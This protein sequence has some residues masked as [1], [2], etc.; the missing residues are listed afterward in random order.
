MLD[1]GFWTGRR[2]LLTGHTGFKGAWLWLMLRRLGARPYGLALEPATK[3][4][5]FNEAGLASDP[6]SCVG[7]I[8][9]PRTVQDA[10]DR[11]G[12]D[13]IIHMAA[14]ALV[15]PSYEN[16]IETYQTNVMGTVNLLEAVRRNHGVRAV[17][18]VTSDKCYRNR[19]WAWAYRE[20]EP[21]GGHDPYSS[22][23]ACAEIVAESWRASFFGN[24]KAGIATARAGNVIGGGDWSPDRLVVD[25]AKAFLD[26]R[27]VELRRPAS[28]RPWQHVLEPLTGYLTLAKALI[29]TPDAAQAWNF[30][31]Y[32]TDA[33]RVD[34]LVA[35]FAT[36]WGDG[37]RWSASAVAVHH[38]AGS[39][40]IDASKAR[41]RLGWK[42]KLDVRQAASWTADWYRRWASGEAAASLCTEQ[43]ETYFSR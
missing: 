21:L 12:P 24:G 13:I 34:A 43:I 42:P 7:D 27:P 35:H 15:Y 29:E 16:P 2:V 17:V 10:I 37:A 25:C 41:E 4:S 6:S 26:G 19:E 28:T 39:L 20:D 11:A 38:E 23:K 33:I 1:G 22:S 32:E 8:R 36:A 30:G 14:Q 31:P 3:P 40:K 5:L 18:V 9:D